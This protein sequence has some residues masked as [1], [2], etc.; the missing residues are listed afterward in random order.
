MNKKYKIDR[1]IDDRYAVWYMDFKNDKGKLGIY[2]VI[3]LYPGNRDTRFAI[4]WK[5]KGKEKSQEQLDNMIIE[6]A[7]RKFG[8]KRGNRFN[9]RRSQIEIV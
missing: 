9:N 4:R 3:D 6:N 5:V 1:V 2:R 8:N 7:I